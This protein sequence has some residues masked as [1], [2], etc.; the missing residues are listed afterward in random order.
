MS[1]LVLFVYFCV[2]LA[3]CSLWDGIAQA[4]L[5]SPSKP[6]ERRRVAPQEPAE[7]RI[8]LIPTPARLRIASLKLHGHNTVVKMVVGG[9]LETRFSSAGA[10]VAEHV[11]QAHGIRGINGT[12]FGYSDPHGKVNLIGMWKTAKSGRYNPGARDIPPEKLRYRPLVVWD[13]HHILFIP[14]YLV[15]QGGTR[16]LQ[17]RMPDA[18]N[19]FL[20][21]AW[22]V[23]KGQAL[24]KEQMTRFEMHDLQDVRP[25]AFLG[26][27][28]RGEFVIGATSGRSDTAR[29]GP[30]LV[31]AGLQEVVLLDSGLSTCLVYKKRV[32]VA[33]NAFAKASL[34]AIPHTIIVYNYNPAH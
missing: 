12:F 22:I 8:S 29:L 11:K 26:V 10:E 19:A 4:Q 28:R 32:V 31:K 3:G 18:S 24:R 16:T 13:R 17:Q 2:C 15:Q 20:A 25:R 1:I 21:G 9:R 5:I 7:V 30:V 23:H 34:R 27:T 14:Y 6:S 33:G